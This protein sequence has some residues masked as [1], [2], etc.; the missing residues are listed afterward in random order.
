MTGQTSIPLLG[1]L[2]WGARTRWIATNQSTN[3][4]GLHVRRSAG[5]GWRRNHYRTLPISKHLLRLRVDKR[6]RR[7]QILGRLQRIQRQRH[8]RLRCWCRCR[9]SSTT[10]STRWI[11]A[12]SYCRPPSIPRGDPTVCAIPCR[13]RR[14]V[15]RY[16]GFPRLQQFDR[17]GN[18]PRRPR[19]P[20][21]LSAYGL[22][23]VPIWDTEWGMEAPTVIT[24]TTAQEAY[25]STGLILQS[26][27]RR[28]NRNFLWL[29]Q[30]QFR[31]L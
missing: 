8:R 11:R 26:A 30:R 14:S 1:C 31:S 4:Y 12:L 2:T 22:S 16:R 27:A 24:D 3:A 23:N 10:P 21:V 20:S 7:Y 9:K 17:R 6:Q 13:R 25:V 19:F 29:R 5:M 28:A 18:C 15:F